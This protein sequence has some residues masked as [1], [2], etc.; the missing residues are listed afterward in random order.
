MTKVLVVDDSEVDRRLIGGLLEQQPDCQVLYAA[1][2]IE[3]LD[4]MKQTAADVIVTDLRMPRMDGLELVKAVRRG[5]PGVPVVLITAH[6][7]KMLAVEALKQGA[8]GY[9]PK[10]HVGDKLLETVQDVLAMA[11]ADR[12]YERLIH[13]LQ[14]S[15]FTFLL[16]LENDPVLID[17]LIELVKQTVGRI[18]LCD[19]TGQLRIGVALKAALLNAILRGNL[20]ISREQ[21]EAARQ[22]RI[23][24]VAQRRSQPPYRDRRVYVDV[25]V[26]R[27]R[28]RFII[29]DEGPGFDVSSLPDLMDSTVGE[30]QAGR[31][32]SLMLTFMDEVTFNEVGNQVTM[33]KYRD[34]V[35]AGVA[36]TPAGVGGR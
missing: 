29:R 4:R 28:A 36:P 33:V 10:I 11:R 2:G 35:A 14:K 16:E 25:N 22:K 21:M 7:S 1:D 13:S 8:A 24:L 31:G 30:R 27:E 20:E 34:A 5:H 9:V 6:G 23:D 12:N 19:F 17:P 15:E 3:A 18:R 32:L 26:S